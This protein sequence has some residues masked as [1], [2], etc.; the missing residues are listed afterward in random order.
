MFDNT[1]IKGNIVHTNGNILLNKCTLYND[2]TSLANYP[3]LLML[4]YC[5]FFND[6]LVIKKITL[7]GNG[8]Y[9]NNFNTY[10]VNNSNF[11]TATRI[12]NNTNYSELSHNHII[13]DVTNL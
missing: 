10:D 2:L 9:T 13:N 12:L 8:L 11:G 1:V 3:N 5:N 7:T 6:T 4:N